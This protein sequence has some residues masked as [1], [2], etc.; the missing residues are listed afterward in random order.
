MGEAEV[1]LKGVRLLPGFLP[2]PAQEA[3]LR[4]VLAVMEAAPPVRFR[5]RWGG[6]MSV[7]MT[8][9]GRFGWTSGPKGYA[10]AEAHPEGTPWP[11]IPDAVL[12]VWDALLP[13]ARAPESC[14]VNLYRGRARMGLHQDRDE[15]DLLAPVLSISLGDEAL[16]R[17]GAAARGGPTAS[18]WLRSGDVAILD[19]PG[20]LAFH[21]IDRVREGSSALVPGGGRINL[22]LRVVT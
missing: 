5:T 19:G 18:A 12:A 22:T 17:V 6:Q 3:I 2:P 4:D 15:A 20:R 9:A 21:G 7:A 8:A 14:L 11:P 13:C 16:F 1:D 10:Y